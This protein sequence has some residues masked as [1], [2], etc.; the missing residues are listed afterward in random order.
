V[1]ECKPLAAG[2]HRSLWCG[3]AA[4]PPPQCPHCAGGCRRTPPCQFSLMSLRRLIHTAKLSCAELQLQPPD[5]AIS[6]TFTAPQSWGRPPAPQ[7]GISWWTEREVGIRRTASQRSP[8]WCPRQRRRRR[9]QGVTLV[10]VPAYSRPFDPCPT[11]S[12]KSVRQAKDWTSGSPW[13][14]TYTSMLIESRL[15]QWKVSTYPT[16]SAYA[17]LKSGRV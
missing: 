12:A 17:E 5:T 7:C 9:R 13:F 6:G 10:H 1:E 2:R 14:H 3:A 16:E 4:G 8:S 11:Y 15:C